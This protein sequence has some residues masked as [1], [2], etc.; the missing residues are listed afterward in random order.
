MKGILAMELRL[1]E[2]KNDSVRELKKV[3]LEIKKTTKALNENKNSLKNNKQL[4]ENLKKYNKLGNRY[5]GYKVLLEFRFRDLTKARVPAAMG[6]EP[7]FRVPMPAAPEQQFKSGI[8]KD[9]LEIFKRVLIQITKENI[10]NEVSNYVTDVIYPLA[11]RSLRTF[12][13][14]DSF[15]LDKV[16]MDQAAEN[17]GQVSNFLKNYVLFFKNKSSEDVKSAVKALSSAFGDEKGF[18]KMQFK[19]EIMENP[20]ILDYNKDIATTSELIDI[21]EFVKASTSF[22][23]SPLKSIGDFFSSALDGGKAGGGGGLFGRKPQE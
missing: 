21:P 22:F 11:V 12:E 3:L 19:N 23:K 8:I 18:D 4:L 10:G 7:K 17:M 6:T 20:E 9:K 1:K 2:G 16:E 14:A 15:K 5:L 13:K